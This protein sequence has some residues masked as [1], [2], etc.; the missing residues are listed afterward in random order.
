MNEN[1]SLGPALRT[2]RLTVLGKATPVPLI[3]W[4]SD[5]GVIKPG[6]LGGYHGI[7][8]IGSELG[9][10]MIPV[11]NPAFLG[12][13]TEWDV[14]EYAIGYPP[15]PAAKGERSQSA[16]LC[17]S[18]SKEQEQEQEYHHDIII[19]ILQDVYRS[20]P[21]IWHPPESNSCDQPFLQNYKTNRLLVGVF[22]DKPRLHSFGT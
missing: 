15:T 2:Q 13:Y 6:I 14:I 16:A 10:Q 17:L 7:Y 8:F 3:I 18:N 5:R 20:V 1:L 4:T 11:C 22:L 12:G 19:G 9:Y 21:T